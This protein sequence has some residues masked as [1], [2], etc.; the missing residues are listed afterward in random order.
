MK[1][2]G[3]LAIALAAGCFEDPG[4]LDQGTSTGPGDDGSTSGAP[5]TTSGDATTSPEPDSSTTAVDPD[6]TTAAA[7]VCGDMQVD[8]GEDCDDGNDVEADGCTECRTSLTPQWVE[9]FGSDHPGEGAFAVAAAQDAVAVAGALAGDADNSDLWIEVL[10]D[11][12]GQ[13]GRVL[14]DGGANQPDAAIDVRFELGGGLWSTGAI[15]AGAPTQAQVDVRRLTGML[16][17]DWAE[18][19]GADN[20]PDRGLGLALVEGGGVV[21]GWV[22]MGLGSDAWIGRYDDEGMLLDQYQCD[23]G[24]FGLA[25][26]VAALPN[27]MRALAL[28]GLTGELWGFDDALA[29]GPTWEVQFETA[30]APNGLAMTL[31]GDTIVCGTITGGNDVAFWLA[32]FDPSGDERW[33]ATHDLGDGDQACRAVHAGGES[34]IAVGE[35]REDE[36]S[37]RG[38]VARIDLSTGDLIGAQELVV[39]DS[40]DTR[41]LGVDAAAGVPYVAGAYAVDAVD[42]NAF[43]A[44]LVP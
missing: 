25:I 18:Q 7:P 17:T 5:A 23:C 13:L 11:A 12:G 3:V 16:D 40:A 10:D 44:R 14:V 37:A 15:D 4:E 24:G 28:D 42:D 22:G 8:D 2:V 36:D 35:I 20:Q 26:D 33:T 29:T 43:A 41:V 30:V 21:A 27:R 34:A 39:E 6:T 31:D 19:V 9:I 38:L 1:R 32:R